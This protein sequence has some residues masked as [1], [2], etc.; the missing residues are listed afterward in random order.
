MAET[1]VFCL[2]TRRENMKARI[3]ILLLLVFGPYSD[4]AVLRGVVILN[5]LEGPGMAGVAVS[6]DGAAPTITDSDGR[7]E[8]E[9]PN[10]RPGDAVEIMVNKA[11]YQVIHSILLQQM[12]PADPQAPRI[13]VLIAKEGDREAMAKQF[14]RL[15]GAEAEKNYKRRLEELKNRNQIDSAVSTQ[16]KE[17][18]EQVKRAP[19]RAAEELTKRK[20]DS[21][22]EMYKKALQLFV[23]GQFER[24]LEVLAQMGL[25][26]EGAGKAA[27]A[28]SIFPVETEEKALYVASGKIG[29]IGDVTIHGDGRFTYRM[30]GVGPSQWT[31]TY[32]DGVSN[33][34]P[35][36]FAGVVWLSPA[37]D[38]GQTDRKCG[39][40]LTGFRRLKWEARA[41]NGPAKVEF[42]IG[43]ITW[44]WGKNDR[45]IPVKVD[46]PYRDTMDRVGLG[47]KML[48]NGWQSFEVVLTNEPEKN[49]KRVVGGFGWVASW[50]SNDVKADDTQRRPLQEKV[51]EFEVRNVRYEK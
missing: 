39:Y 28:G 11:D 30:K 40:D 18:F 5:Q 24:S 16:L 3:I 7:F 1:T 29:D 44:N 9:F 12:L 13:K 51:I 2:D 35:A 48:T 38:W 33:T 8:L 26:D 42:F 31:Y 23:N 32:L 43:G 36:M 10:R 4:A 41:I 6:A 19:E 50:A 17:N 25:A 46:A 20:S 37:D 14:F 27:P 45:G 47:I 34:L 21:G 15:K 22:S 49:F